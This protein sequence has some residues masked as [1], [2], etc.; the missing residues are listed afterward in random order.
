MLKRNRGPWGPDPRRG[1]R[2][3][4]F[5][6]DAAGDAVPM[7]DTDVMYSNGVMAIWSASDLEEAPTPTDAVDEWLVRALTD[8][9]TD[10]FGGQW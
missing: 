4:P 2:P 5:K 8:E 9:D 6:L 3:V 7:S 10:G 1:V